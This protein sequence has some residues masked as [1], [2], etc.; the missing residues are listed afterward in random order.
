MR[1]RALILFAASL[2]FGLAAVVL[3]YQWL[4]R[5]AAAPAVAAPMPAAPVRNTLSSQIGGEHRAVTIRVNDVLG[6]GGFVL[7]GDR[8][9]VMLTR[10]THETAATDVLLQNVKV[11]GVDQDA[12]ERKDKPTVARAVTLEVS[13]E[14]AQRVILGSQVGTLSL[15]LRNGADAAARSPR[16]VGLADLRPSVASVRAPAGDTGAAVRVLRGTDAV[17]MRVARDR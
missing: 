14:E 2:V 12:N 11:L 7:P 1:H 15:A 6:V 9:D 17:E 16:T 13:A 4:S 5:G 8:V 10:N 3:A